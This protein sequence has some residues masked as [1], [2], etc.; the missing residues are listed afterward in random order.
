MTVGFTRVVIFP[1]RFKIERK[2]YPRGDPGLCWS[3]KKKPTIKK[4]I[5]DLGDFTGDEK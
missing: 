3:K 1:V 4:E 5:E 2:Q